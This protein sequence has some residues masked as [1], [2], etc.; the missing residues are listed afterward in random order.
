MELVEMEEEE[1]EDAKFQVLRKRGEEIGIR[2]ANSEIPE[3]FILSP[4]S[5]VDS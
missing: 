1:E 2:A 4:H 3:S 5:K